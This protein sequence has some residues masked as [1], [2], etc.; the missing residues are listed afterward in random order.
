MYSWSSLDPS[1]GF[2]P[3][4]RP[5]RGDGGRIQKY[6][7]LVSQ[8]Y[9]SAL[10]FR[11]CLCH[12]A[13]QC[14]LVHLLSLSRMKV[15]AVAR[16]S[17]VSRSQNLPIENHEMQSTRIL[18]CSPTLLQR[19][20][21][22]ASRLRKYITVCS[23]L[24]DDEYGEHAA[25][26]LSGNF[27]PVVDEISAEHV[28]APEGSTTDVGN[29]DAVSGLMGG[30][31]SLTTVGKLPDDFPDGQFVYVGPNPKFPQEHYK[32][33]GKGPKQEQPGQANGWHH[34]FEGDGMVFAVDFETIRPWQDC[35][36]CSQTSRSPTKVRRLRYRNRYVRTNSWCDEMRHGSRL[37]RPLMNTTGSAFLPNAFANFFLGGNVL[38]DSANTALTYFCGKLL[39]L[40]DTM[41]P[42]ELDSGT[43]ETRGVHNFNGT[44]PFYLPFTAHPKIVAG[45]ENLIFFGFN[46]VHPP[47]CSV[48]SVDQHGQVGKITALW[49]DALR[50]ATF[51][52]D[53]CVTLNYTVL[54]EGSMNI[55][56]FR[57][58][59]GDHPLKY[60]QCQRARFGIMRRDGKDTAGDVEWCECTTAQMVYHFVNAW[61]DESTGE[62]VVTG[63]REDGFFH[64]ALAARG[65]REWINKALD[66][67]K[68]VPRMHEWRIDPMR[69]V[70]TSEK[71]LFDDL[72][73]VPRINDAFT[74][75]RNRFAYA[76]RIH[77]GSLR[78]DAQLKF[79]AVLKFDL[80]SGEKQV[81]EHG[82]GRFGMETQFVSRGSDGYFKTELESI[83][84]QVSDNAE[85]RCDDSLAE[86]DGWLILYVHDESNTSAAAAEC[87]SECVIL[88]ARNIEAGPV[89]RIVLP[90]RVPYGAHASWCPADKNAA[91]PSLD[92]ASHIPKGKAEHHL[93]QRM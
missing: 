70:V 25:A 92:H 45:T 19:P 1:V 51:M 28:I 54:F 83:L 58:L 37:F 74:G 22:T 41:P 61:E 3:A 12:W 81:Y 40:Q 64:G 69:G 8:S 47:H 62:I 49:H 93:H 36:S 2:P 66:E 53:F 73:E 78:N 50:G 77:T 6:P 11:S 91:G 9:R 71:W 35:A 90:S 31:G 87:H 67:D 42:W 17:M 84:K 7:R 59:N 15:G 52:H 30:S 82:G 85:Q 21:D 20:G 34:W 63:V 80:E 18:P 38:K 4:L 5:P 33:W 39:A 75:I 79:D 65:A 10:R 89:L 24:S 86:D 14:L 13:R 72:V 26:F 43:L 46:P 48:G 60:D 88:D 68:C 55:R 32:A 29:S 76:G 16:R 23:A 27:Q 44:L 56:P 57:I